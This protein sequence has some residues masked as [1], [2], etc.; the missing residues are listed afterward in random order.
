M[1]C[2]FTIVYGRGTCYILVEQQSKGIPSN[3]IGNS[4]A[5][6]CRW[7]MYGIGYGRD[8]ADSGRC[9]NKNIMMLNL[10]LLMFAE[11]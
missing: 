8:W 2:G 5:I 11:K 4:N 7:V 6:A 3:L 9:E 10:H 1:L